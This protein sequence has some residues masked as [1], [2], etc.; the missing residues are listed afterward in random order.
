MERPRRHESRRDEPL[1][2][3]S[4]GSLG[5]DGG[6]RSDNREMCVGYED[7]DLS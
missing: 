7:G 2:F 1:A 6:L 5:Y 3:E 4:G